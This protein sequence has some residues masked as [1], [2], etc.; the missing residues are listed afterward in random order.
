MSTTTLLTTDEPL[1]ILRNDVPQH[2]R[3]DIKWFSWAYVPDLTLQ[4]Y[5]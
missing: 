1:I 3:Q 2:L 4:Y 5:S